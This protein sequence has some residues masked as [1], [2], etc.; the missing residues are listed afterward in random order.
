MKKLLCILTALLLM[1][2]FSGCLKDD[3]EALQAE[4]QEKEKIIDNTKDDIDDLIE[5]YDNLILEKEATETE[6]DDLIEISDNLSNEASLLKDKIKET[7]DDGLKIT[8][9]E[10]ALA[11]SGY[12]YEY[13]NLIQWKFPNLLLLK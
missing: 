13:K 5:N 1:T 7:S 9:A 8:A 2:S 10:F 4:I 11:F 3:Y 6:L 12:T